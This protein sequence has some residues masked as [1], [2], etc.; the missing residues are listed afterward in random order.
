MEF[1]QMKP[2]SD[3]H[4]DESISL[5][6]IVEKYLIHWKWFVFSVLIVGVLAFFKLRYEV[7]QYNINATILIK[8]NEK[9]NSFTDLSDFEDLGL[10]GSGGDNSLE[11]EMQILKSR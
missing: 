9:G 10:F 5:R 1:E 6:E 3:E 7:P 2:L 11:N 4:F 8:K